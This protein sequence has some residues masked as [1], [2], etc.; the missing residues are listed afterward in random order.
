VTAGS[1]SS[2]PLDKRP[3]RIG[4]MFDVIAPRYDLLNHLLSAGLD[5]R[6]RAR[7]IAS[8]RLAGHE[9]LA[10]VCTGTGDVL[11]AALAA[12]RP[13]ARAIGLDFASAMLQRGREKLR[14]AA[15]GRAAW[16]VRA[17]ATCLPLPSASV[18]AVTVAFGIRNVQ[19][20]PLALVEMLRVLR[21]GGRV[22]ILEFGQPSMPVLRGLYAWYFRSVLPR[23]GRLVSR[24]ESAYS[25]L[26]ASVGEFPSGA[27]FASVLMRAGFSEVRSDRLALGVVYLY[28]AVRAA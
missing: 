22:A 26:P 19:D 11:V 17:D 8:L 18:D 2:D 28:S 15:P 25:Y 21:P 16:V 12:R 6:W 20:L 24:H 23:I 4:A 9:T 14:R 1:P 27:R 5:R 13:P 7:A 10:D 3:A